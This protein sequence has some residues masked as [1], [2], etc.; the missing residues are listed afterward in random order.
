MPPVL[1]SV[2]PGRCK[3][4]THSAC[5]GLVGAPGASGLSLGA[6][7]RGCVLCWGVA[8]WALPVVV[9]PVLCVCAATYSVHAL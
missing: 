6:G 9:F 8:G 4:Q 1:Y 3:Q 2:Q 5:A 7:A